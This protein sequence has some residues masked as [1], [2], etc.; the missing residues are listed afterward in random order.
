MSARRGFEPGRWQTP[1]VRPGSV[2]GQLAAYTQS[3]NRIK[4]G[5]TTQDKELLGV[6]YVQACWGTDPQAPGLQA[7]EA[8]SFERG[9]VTGQT[10]DH[11]APVQVGQS[12]PLATTGARHSQPALAVPTVGAATQVAAAAV[13]KTLRQQ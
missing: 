3:R 8:P 2:R 1:D 7:R 6:R 13:R 9:S 11:R 4:C 5:S 10:C 12:G